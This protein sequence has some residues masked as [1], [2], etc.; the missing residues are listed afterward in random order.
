[1]ED[2]FGKYLRL[3][4]SIFFLA[5]G[6]LVALVLVLLAVR[7]LFGLMSYIPWITYI[8]TLFILLI[9]ATLFVTTF[10]IYFKRTFSHPDKFA[11]WISYF[12]FSAAL[13]AWAIFLFSDVL[14]FYEHAYTTIGMY[15]SYDMIFLASNVACIFIV[16]VI[17]AL[18][19][20][21][22][23]DWMEKRSSRFDV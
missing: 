20:A 16:G 18:T 5:L 17:Q 23:K 1:M 14:I 12:L 10:I 21:K 4:G 11:R 6:S 19:T 9:P 2:H 3:F 15:H 8:Y 7:L 22:E 13:I